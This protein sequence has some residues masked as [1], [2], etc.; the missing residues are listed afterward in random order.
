MWAPEKYRDRAK[1][2]REKY[3]KGAEEEPHPNKLKQKYLE[4]LSRY[5]WKS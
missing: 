3:S 1:E 5:C 2:R 4:S